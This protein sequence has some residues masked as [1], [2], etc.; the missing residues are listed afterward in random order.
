MSEPTE[1]H[2][3]KTGPT[4]EARA[5]GLIRTLLTQRVTP[6]GIVQ[7]LGATGLLRTEPTPADG[8]TAWMRDGLRVLREALDIPHAATVGGD[9]VRQELLKDRAMY[10]VIALDALDRPDIDARG[11]CVTI[12][13]LREKLAGLE[14]TGYVSTTQ[15]QAA[16][17]EGKTWVE[18][19]TLPGGES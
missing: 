5:E 15:A 3:P 6:A 2:N 1:Q 4:V 8:T 7:E 17:A 10:A 14:P 18:A 19:T 16:L 9:Q 13:Y 11:A 12:D